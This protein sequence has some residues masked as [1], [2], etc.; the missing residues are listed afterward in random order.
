MSVSWA[1]GDRYEVRLGQG[2]LRY[3]EVGSGPALVFVH[4]LLVNGV[5]WRDVV[6]ELS[7]RFRC[8]LPDL[9]LGGHAVPMPGAD[10]SPR[11]VARL[12]AEFV[13][14]LDLRDVTLVG[15]DTGGAVCQIVITEHPGRIGRLVLTNCDAYE[16]FLPWQL[17]LF[18]YG[19][20][21]FGQRFVDVLARVLRARSAQRLLLKTVAKRRMD[22]ATLDAYFGDLIRDAG[23]RGD[24]TRFLQQISNRETLEAARRFSGFRRPVLIVWGEDDYFFLPRYARRLAGD[25]PEARLRFVRG[26]RAFVPEDQPQAL[27]RCIEDFVPSEIGVPAGDG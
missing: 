7:G 26:S 5:L 12:V 22:E 1:G 3:R 6:S 24:V 21:L 11:G 27:A 20:R 4:G 8:V 14:A 19:P 9:P 2:V 18:Q 13:E 15:N 23:V 16:A 10:L 25:F 17:R